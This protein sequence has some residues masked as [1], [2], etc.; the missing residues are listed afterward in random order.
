MLI[1]YLTDY[2][3]EQVQASVI[4]FKVNNKTKLL[5]KEWLAWGMIPGM[6]DDY[7][8]FIVRMTTTLSNTDTIRQY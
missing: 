2:N 8:S 3:Q 5:V 4:L 6:I 1:T 7:Q